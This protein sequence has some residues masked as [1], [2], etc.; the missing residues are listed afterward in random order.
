MTM[1][2]NDPRIPQPNAFRRSTPFLPIPAHPFNRPRHTHSGLNTSVDILV[3]KRSLLA[4]PEAEK[5]R[6]GGIDQNF[7]YNLKKYHNAPP[8]SKTC[9]TKGGGGLLTK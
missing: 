3:N 4:E 5:R 6:G 7:R 8:E 1:A 9:E 2:Q